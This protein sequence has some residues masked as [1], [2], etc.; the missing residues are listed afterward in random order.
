MTKILEKKF[1]SRIKNKGPNIEKKTPVIP[2]FIKPDLR[3]ILFN[4][5]KF[6]EKKYFI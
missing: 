5:N 6:F 1:D 4:I 3:I 2:Y